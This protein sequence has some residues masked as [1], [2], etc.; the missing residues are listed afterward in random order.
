MTTPRNVAAAMELSAA[1]AT[2]E[3]GEMT[4]FGSLRTIMRRRLSEPRTAMAARKSRVAILAYT[5]CAMHIMAL[6]APAAIVAKAM[7]IYVKHL[8]VYDKHTM[9]SGVQ[10][11]QPN[12]VAVPR[13]EE[14]EEDVHDPFADIHQE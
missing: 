13:A 8:H 9:G 12:R 6:A 10:L 2:P 7:H 5:V 3:R 14:P 1:A 4:T 11:R